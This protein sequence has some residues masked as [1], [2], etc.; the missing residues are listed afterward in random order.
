MVVGGGIV[1]VAFAFEGF[2]DQDM[3]HPILR[4]PEQREGIPGIEAHGFAPHGKGDVQVAFRSFRQSA[5]KANDCVGRPMVLFDSANIFQWD[6]VGVVNDMNAACIGVYQGKLIVPQEALKP[7]GFGIEEI[8]QGRG[9]SA[10]SGGQV[11]IVG[12]PGASAPG[13]RDSECV[14]RF[15]QDLRAQA[16][17]A[18]RMRFIGAPRFV[19]IE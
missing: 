4:A 7:A 9:F 19:G 16:V 6:P 11:D 1:E 3:G 13:G 8:E 2:A 5:Y 12:D 10:S 15:G 17:T 14:Q 18:R